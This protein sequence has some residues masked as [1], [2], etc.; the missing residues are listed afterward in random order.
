MLFLRRIALVT[1][2]SFMF[3]GGALG[4]RG[5]QVVNSQPD[6]PAPVDEKEQT[7][8]GELKVLAEGSHSAITNPFVAVVRDAHT[9]AALVKLD[10]NLP[11]LDADFF[12]T[13]AVVAAFLGERNTGGY[14]VEIGRDASGIR[15]QEKKPGKDMMVTQVI[16][17]PFKI[18]SVEGV[19]KSPVLLTLDDA[20]HTGMTPFRV[21]TGR[22]TM[23]GG[24]AGAREEF[25]LGGT[26]GV[27]RAANL[28]TF[29]FRLIAPATTK[30]RA[31]T[32]YATGI[33]SS[34]NN[35]R[36]GRMGADTLINPPSPG[37]AAD[38]MFSDG[39]KKL[40]LNLISRPSMIADG[41]SGRGSFEASA[42][43]G[44]KQ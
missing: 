33:V 2:A 28:A 24:I 41:Y 29:H 23:V 34:D 36:I 27:L 9:Y 19:S 25:D 35:V 22:F 11:K 39:G 14:S 26:I 32:E 3:S 20:W 7:K 38:G 5:R 44:G 4:C 13:N 1:L 10:G 18:I 31:L 37:L 17:A 43:G 16:T 6:T 12:E 21:N 8:Q 42:A 40:Q 30:R 15:V